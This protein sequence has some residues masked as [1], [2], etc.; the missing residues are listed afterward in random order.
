MSPGET[1]NEECEFL[2]FD[3]SLSRGGHERSACL[4]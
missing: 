1:K 2:L 3:A 4:A